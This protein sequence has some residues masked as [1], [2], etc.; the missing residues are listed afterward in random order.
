M[1]RLRP[2]EMW[3]K[4]CIERALPPGCSVGQHDDGSQPS[5]FDL[6]ID[7]PDGRIGAV[8]I[9]V[10]VNAQE[11]ALARVLHQKVRNW[12]VPNLAGVWWAVLRHT[13]QVKD[14]Q[15][16]LPGM[17]RELEQRGMEA[18]RGSA[19]SSD[20]LAV[21]AA[22]LH[23]IQVTRWKTDDAG[24]IFVT[25]QQPMEQMGGFSP[26]TGD[27]VATWL[28][29]WLAEPDQHGNREKLAAS[30]A[31]E[32]HMFVFTAGFTVVP[33]AVTD[34]LAT[35]DC[36]TPTLPPELPPEITDVWV[37]ST[38]REWGDGLRWSPG[39]GWSHFTKVPPS[40][41]W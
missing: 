11:L 20:A 15:S 5:M 31:S 14:I 17:L 38:W 26:A 6:R 36:P 24:R 13:A 23:I 3:A 29:G 2:E 39:I 41:D 27:A 10:A 9:T 1:P 34:L 33:F 12:R 32:R 21:K 18:L 35:S 16:A 19:S 40:D 7:Y 28:S 25:H 37:M 30:G 8:E 4:V 22:E